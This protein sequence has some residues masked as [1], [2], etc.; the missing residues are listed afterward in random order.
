MRH[1]FQ[2]LEKSSSISPSLG[3]IA[4][5]LLA[6]VSARG[7]G[8][9]PLLATNEAAALARGLARLNMTEADLDF[10]KDVGEPRLALGWI[11]HVLQHPLDLPARGDEFFQAFSAAE[12][13]PTWDALGRALEAGDAPHAV[14]KT[15][16]LHDLPPEL[17]P[18]LARPLMAFLEAARRAD[19][20][21]SHAFRNLEPAERRALA[22]FALCGEMDA[23]DRPD[24]RAALLAEGLEAA[25]VDRAI[26]DAGALD[27]RPSAGAFLERAGRIDR[28]A[29]LGAGR[30]LQAAV[31]RLAVDLRDFRAWPAAPISI[32]TDLGVMF[33]LATNTSEFAGDALLVVAPPGPT[34]YSGS[35]G[36]ANG[37]RRR[38]L[39][40]LLDLGGDDLYESGGLLGAGAALFGASVV[41]DLGGR[42][43]Y[44]AARLGQ[45]S[46]IFGAAWLEDA[47]G[48]D[49]YDAAIFSQGAGIWGAG[50]LRDD[51]GR[52][53]YGAGQESQGYGGVM[54]AGVLL[55]R[56]GDDTYRAGGLERDADRNVEHTLSLSQGFSIGLRPFAGGGL[57]AL[58]DLGGNDAYTAEVFG[59]GC[60]YWYSAGFL[61]DAGGCDNYTVYQYGQGTGIHLALGLLADGGGKDYY[62][63]FSLAQ[64][65]AHDYAVGM[66]FDQGGD[67]TYTADDGSQGVAIYNSFA[68]LADRAGDDAYFARDNTECQGVGHA[69]A[70]RDYG[71]L[72]VL[73]DLAGEDRYTC[74]ATNGCRLQRPLYGV[75]Y[76]RGPEAKP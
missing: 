21:L 38:P 55:D 19:L 69:G 48:D 13:G 73:L 65:S 60:G 45:G 66:L 42:D 75:V 15:I 47:A 40:A 24:A 27:T 62:S 74:G 49:L 2:P 46:G 12:P 37:L 34:R 30:T 54:G 67:D 23:E 43:T 10:A 16:E 1:V 33:V 53:R 44:R 39:A 6:A 25:D 35:T 20:L 5:V 3:R 14:T 17:S 28:A 50:V 68:L 51:A 72:S 31:A 9:T 8:L 11:R 70:E 52:D 36:S 58:V 76:D 32:G 61:F 41:L 4:A 64:G 18:E 22:A 71:D 56:A 26:A 63:A 59:Q 29:L 7:G 57:G